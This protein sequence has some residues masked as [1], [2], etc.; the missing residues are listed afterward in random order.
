MS[1]EKKQPFEDKSTILITMHKMEE[2]YYFCK[3]LSAVAVTWTWLTTD[4]NRTLVFQQDF[5]CFR[6]GRTCK[7]DRRG[8]GTAIFLNK[9]WHALPKQSITFNNDAAAVSCRTKFSCKMPCFIICSTCSPPSS[10][11]S[12]LT[13]FYLLTTPD[14]GAIYT[15]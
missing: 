10:S 14:I 11:I 3:N 13:V 7:R 12:Q 8:G 2:K 4:I 5:R 6:T 9:C 15:L 1:K